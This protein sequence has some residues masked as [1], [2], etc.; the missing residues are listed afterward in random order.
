MNILRAAVVVSAS[1]LGDSLLY[2]ALP[3]LYSSFGLNI[4]HVG[5]LLSANRLVRFVSNTFAGYVY[6]RKPLKWVLVISII[7]AFFINL[8]YGY[9][10]GFV[11]FLLMRLC[12]GI[13]WSFLRLGGYLSVVSF[14]DGLNMGRYMGIYQSIS[15]IGFLSGG[16]VGG[17]LLDLWGY[18]SANLL[19]AFGTFLVIPIAFS[20]T[21]KR[22]GSNEKDQDYSFDLHT[23]IG[24]TKLLSIGIGVM[25]TRLFFGSLIS[26]TLSLYLVEVLGS[27]GVTLL[28]RGLGVASL[29]GFLL[30]F[31]LFS[32]F[33]FSPISGVLSDKLG[34]QRTMII[35][36]I[37]GSISLLILAFS[38][39]LGM[40]TIAV[41]LSFLSDT[42]LGVVMASKVSDMVK[43]DDAT[44][45]YTLSAFTNWI[46]I[47]SGIGPLVIFS[48]LS[49]ISFNYLF[50]GASVS[51]ILYAMFVQRAS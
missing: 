24:N 14:S 18:T 39:S 50:V 44:S 7:V 46:D 45:Q 19:L 49:E 29:T 43:T 11:P 3:L 33:L 10:G 38:R 17:I 6:G 28:G 32:K 51:L 9:I 22:L 30:S 12:W 26:S 21:D 5:I 34:R 1:N 37:S 27:E 36:L 23:L 16:L 4:I 2:V 48:L 41:I 47:G 40:I 35:L 25:L 8:S 31:R 15:S 42:G 13:T 20:L